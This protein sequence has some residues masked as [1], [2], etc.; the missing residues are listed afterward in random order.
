MTTQTWTVSDVRVE[1]PLIHR[2]GL[3]APRGEALPPLASGAAWRAFYGC[4]CGPSKP[5]N[6]KDAKDAKDS[7]RVQQIQ[8]F[9]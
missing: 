6:A 7:Q 5:P 4:S 9:N 1:T 8:K 2:I 3:V